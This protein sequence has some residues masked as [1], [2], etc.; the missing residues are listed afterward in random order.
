MEVRNQKAE[1]AWTT[2]QEIYRYRKKE[3]RNQKGKSY[4]KHGQ[5]K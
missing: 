1:Q 2:Q 4:L 5:L 3:K